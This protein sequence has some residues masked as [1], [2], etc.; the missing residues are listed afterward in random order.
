VRGAFANYVD[1]LKADFKSIAA[2]GWGAELIPDE[3][4][5]QSLTLPQKS[6]QVS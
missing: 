5:L 3:K 4:I 6:G 1:V 2:S